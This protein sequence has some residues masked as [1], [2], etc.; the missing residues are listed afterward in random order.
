[1]LSTLIVL[2]NVL[3]F[4]TIMLV[5]DNPKYSKYLLLT[6]SENLD[7]FDKLY[8]KASYVAIFL[9]FFDLVLLALFPV[10]YWLY[11]LYRKF[12]I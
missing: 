6:G 4:L 12:K 10:F 11:Y 3:S 7:L 1:M 9:I 8:Y 5:S 2:Y